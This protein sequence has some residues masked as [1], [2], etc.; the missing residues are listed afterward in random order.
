MSING[1]VGI[2]TGQSEGELCIVVYLEN[3]S[4]GLAAQI[5]DELKGYDVVTEVTGLSRR[6]GYWAAPTAVPAFYLTIY[7]TIPI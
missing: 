3:D 7:I 4:A 6:C 1:V 2:G 5:P